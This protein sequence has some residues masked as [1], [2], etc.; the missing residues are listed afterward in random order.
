MKKEKKSESIQPYY[1]AVGSFRDKGDKDCQLYACEESPFAHVGNHNTGSADV[2]TKV[3]N[4]ITTKV[5]PERWLQ[6]IEKNKPIDDS[7]RLATAE[8]FDRYKENYRHSL[9]KFRRENINGIGLL[10]GRWTSANRIEVYPSGTNYYPDKY[11]A[12]IKSSRVV[13]RIRFQDEECEDDESPIPNVD[14]TVTD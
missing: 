7:L 14:V 2:C 1:E 12:F 11:A 6:I 5:P 13:K 3:R 9:S 4:G 8:E 10:N